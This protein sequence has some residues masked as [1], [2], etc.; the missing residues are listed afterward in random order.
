MNQ[1]VFV[2]LFGYGVSLRTAR[3]WKSRHAHGGQDALADRSSRPRGCRNKLSELDFCQIYTLR[4]ERKTGDEIALRL[5]FAEAVF[6][7]FCGNLPVHGYHHWNTRNQF[8]A[9]NGR[10]QGKC[11]TLDIKKLGKIDG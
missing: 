4:K 6:F 1:Q 7:V 3:K 11:C 5:A 8:S 2:V 10:I 9:I